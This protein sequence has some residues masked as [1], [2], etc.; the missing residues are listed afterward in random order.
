MHGEWFITG[1]LGWLTADDVL[2]ITGRMKEIIVLSN[3]ENIE[4][5]GLED[6][7]LEIPYIEQIMITG[8]DKP[9]L[10]ALVY[11]NQD[12]F[13][14]ALP[15][16]SDEDPNNLEDFK[17][18]LLNEINKK[19]KSRRNF[20]SFERINDITFLKEGFTIENGMMTQSLKIKKNVVAERYKAEIKAM[21]L[22]K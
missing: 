20:R 7:C 3:G 21:Y 22:K 6:V 2:V 4:A 15:K 17:S 18:L 13:R 11:L 8:Q 1:D 9:Y 14:S 10:T 16:K 5:E 19:I 12:E